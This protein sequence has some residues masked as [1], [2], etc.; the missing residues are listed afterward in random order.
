M[1]L[2]GKSYFYMNME[3][4][5]WLTATVAA[6]PD[7]ETRAFWERVNASHLNQLENLP[8]AISCIG[9][10]LAMG[11]DK[12]IIDY[13]SCFYLGA[14]A[15]YI[16][17][18]LP[19]Q[20]IWLGLLRTTF[21]T[22]RLLLPVFALG[23]GFAARR[24]HMHLLGFPFVAWS[25][26]N[27]TVPVGGFVGILIGVMGARRVQS[28]ESAFVEDQLNKAGVPPEAPASPA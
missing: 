14:T 18:Y 27:F 6:M 4:R 28:Q 3:P 2:G 10:A 11:A 24:H 17:V 9:V 19:K 7:P 21:Y 5:K 1:Q 12:A 16:A 13:V 23:A 15:L 8:F 26:V 25:I 22:F 20:N